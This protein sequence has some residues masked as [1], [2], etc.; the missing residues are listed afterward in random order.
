[1]ARLIAANRRKGH[2]ENYRATRERGLKPPS[3]KYF[4]DNQAD[5]RDKLS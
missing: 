4:I 5:V 2:E 1:M 3:R